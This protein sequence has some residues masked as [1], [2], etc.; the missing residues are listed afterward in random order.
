MSRHFSGKVHV[1]ENRITRKNGI[2]YVYERTT[3]YDQKSRK[4]LTIST[5]LVGKIMHGETKMIP[6][7]HRKPNGFRKAGVLAVRRHVGLTDILEWAGRESCIDQDL[8]ESF[9]AGDAAKIQSIARYWL[10]T[11]GSTLPRLEG[12][13]LMHELPYPHGISEDVYGELFKTLGCNEGGIQGFFMARAGRL[14]TMPVIAY[15]STTISTYSRNQHEARRGFNKARD[16]LDTIKLLTLYSVKDEEPIAFAKQPGN[17]PD[18]I[19]IDNAIMQFKCLGIDSPLVT[20]DTGYCSEPNLCEL[21]RRNMK[22]LTLID[23]DTK[24]AGK[25]VDALRGKL[26]SMGAVCP[27]DYHVSGATMTVTHEFSFRRERTRNGIAAGETETFTRRLHLYVFKSNELWEKHEEAFRQKLME[28]KQLVEQGTTEFTA[29]ARERIE[30]YLVCSRTGR[31]GRLHVSFNEDTCA[32]A[33]KYFGYFV[34]VSNAPL[35]V[36]EALEDYRMRERIEELFQAEKENA[37]GRRPRLWHPDAL[38]GRMFVQFISLCY[39]CFIMKKIKAMKSA[40]GKEDG[41]KTEKRLELERKLLNWLKQRS[42]AQIF[43]WFDCL[44]ET[45]VKT[46][47][48]AR[49][50][51][52][53]AVARDRLFLELL[54][55]AKS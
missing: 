27:F 18:V 37:D 32:E 54:G 19:S 55:V 25:A 12:W 13:Q 21:C 3:R 39:R 22:F 43:D 1:G 28:L 26:D 16:G 40:L 30:K 33:R 20:T 44:E 48:G 42:L 34:L 5:R 9:S 10:G 11:D 6:T 31:G 2:T 7:R 36:F 49:R 38:K 52:T 23:T 17:I 8:E 24:M 51:T 35:E 46:P 41:Q 45:T 29:A 47:A 15:D 53:E 50:W 14:S 4:T